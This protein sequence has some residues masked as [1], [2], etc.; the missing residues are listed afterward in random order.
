M[1]I[2]NE[3]AYGL[4]HFKQPL[5]CKLPAFDA[6]GLHRSTQLQGSCH[7]ASDG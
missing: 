6:N 3:L 1:M 4:H 7:Q 5:Q 2:A